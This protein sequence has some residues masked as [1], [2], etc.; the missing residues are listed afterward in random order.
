MC[1][2]C[3]SHLGGGT[4]GI[5]GSKCSAG[6]P[7]GPHARNDMVDRPTVP[8]RRRE[9]EPD[10]HNRLREAAC[11]FT[12]VARRHRGGRPGRQAGAQGHLRLLQGALVP[13]EGVLA[14]G[15]ACGRPAN[16]AGR[17]RLYTRNR[18]VRHGRRIDHRPER[19][20][21]IRCRHRRHRPQGNA[22]CEGLG[23]DSVLEGWNVR[24]RG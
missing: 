18:R 6:N 5:T 15:G 22:T 3:G 8:H 19:V 13:R 10:R 12:R 17:S 7:S 14:C 9:R 4:N 1:A 11:G 20:R 24:T 23:H 21:G 16:R 2:R